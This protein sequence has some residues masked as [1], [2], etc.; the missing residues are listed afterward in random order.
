M[1]KVIALFLLILLFP[2]LLIISILILIEDG[3]PIFYKQEKYGINNSK[4]L[5]YKFRTMYKN[6]P[7]I[8]TQDFKNAT[9]YILISGKIFRKMSIDEIPQL[10]NIVKG[11]MNFIGPR[12][13]MTS[14]ENILFNLRNK[15]GVNKLKPGI[16]GWAQVNG[17]DDNSFDEKA[18]YDLYYLKNK[19]L[20]LDIKII[21]K[22]F[23]I[24]F[25]FKKIVH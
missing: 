15:S 1:N 10:I 25:N 3:F 20:F 6:T 19:N 17:R 11:E 5:M 14:N 9:K 23:K 16:T 24:L 4:F 21:F 7:L 18:K 12:P 13:C 22:T 8:P 2:F